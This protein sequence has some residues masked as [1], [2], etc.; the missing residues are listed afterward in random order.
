MGDPPL[1]SNIG[2]TSLTPCEDMP[3]GSY[4]EMWGTRHGAWQTGV[5]RSTAS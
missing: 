5:C 3:A 1:G 2:W 4:E